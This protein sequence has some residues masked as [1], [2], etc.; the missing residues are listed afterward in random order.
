MGAWV[1]VSLKLVLI[2]RDRTF[3]SDAVPCYKHIFG[4]HRGPLN[5]KNRKKMSE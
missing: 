5:K 4:P 3:N 1:G 2:A